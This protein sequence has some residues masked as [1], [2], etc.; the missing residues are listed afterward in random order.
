MS[1]PEL[2]TVS[3][4]LGLKDAMNLDGGGSSTLWTDSTGI[5]NY[6]YDNKKFDHE[7]AR[8]VPNVIV[9]K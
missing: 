9:V 6:P 8:K 3:R 7:G 5:V 4:L 1:I 2:A